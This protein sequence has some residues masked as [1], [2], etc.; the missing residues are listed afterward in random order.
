MS[1]IPLTGCTSEPLINYLKA[2]GIL[3]L[4]NEQAEASARASWHDGVFFLR[5]NLDEIGLEDFFCTS[6]KPTPIIVPWSGNDFFNIAPLAQ[7]AVFK[8]T[9][10]GSTVLS[11]F[12]NTTAKRLEKYRE[13]IRVAQKSLGKAAIRTKEEM[14]GR[15]KSLFLSQLRSSVCSES[16]AWIDAAAVIREQK[17]TFSLLLGSGGGNDGNIHFSD[18][19]MQNLWEMLPEFNLQRAPSK[20]NGSHTASSGEL[21]RHA[22]FGFA[23]SAMV[24]DRTSSLF[25]S[26]AVGGPNAG[27]GFERPSISNPWNFILALEGVICFAGALSRRAQP[28]SSSTPSF[29]FQVQAS[30]TGANTLV[31]KEQAGKEIWLPLW[32]RPAGFEEVRLLLSEGRTEIGRR[33]AATGVGVARAVA[34]LGV[35]RG[36][37]AFRRYA[38]VKGRVGGE[39]YVTASSLGEFPVTFHRH[40]DLLR[41]IDPWLRSLRH[42]VSD[43]TPPRFSFALR[44]IERAI[45]DYCR[46]GGSAFFQAILVALGRAEAHLATGES[47]RTNRQTGRTAIRPLGGLSPEWIEA[48]RDNTPEFALALSLAGIYDPSGKIGPLRANL[49][50]VEWKKQCRDW[51]SKDRAVVWNAAHLDANLIAV[52][53]RRL[54]DGTRAGCERLP[55]A[56]SGTA[57]LETITFFLSGGIDEPRLENLLW[58]LMCVR[59][60]ANPGMTTFRPDSRDLL[61][62]PRAFALLKLLFL[63]FPL[64]AEVGEVI[65]KPEPS[66][67]SLLRSGRLAEACVIGLRRLRASGLE[68]LPHRSSSR[69]NRDETWQD[70]CAFDGTR[71]AAALL[72]PISHRDIQTLQDLVLRREE[73][74]PELLERIP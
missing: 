74:K 37:T 73:V 10:S 51:A 50:P 9:P 14:K 17:P 45:F 72:F 39:N 7:Q 69:S 54:M 42:A 38:I 71:L 29:P 52:L 32:R 28:E 31:G 64:R 43:Q 35:D 16:V 23:T 55:L 22:L 61:P 6:Y 24:V 21:L 30:A 68:P 53:Q 25:D 34:S 56:F 49:E 40:V 12:L 66:I 59:H 44:R 3:R 62:L 2:L 57:S 4:V 67:L 41:E 18:N 33:C 13:T 20:G 60:G 26:G 1:T 5:S 19:F 65:I 47:F 11:A 63:P 27:Q 58:G 36:I 8:K 70:A 46:Y 48:A 15:A